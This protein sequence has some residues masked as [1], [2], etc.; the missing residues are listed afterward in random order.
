MMVILQSEEHD[1]N[2]AFCRNILTSLE[3]IEFLRLYQ[4]IVWG[5]NVRRTEAFQVSNI[6]EATTYPFIAIIALQTSPS[7]GSSLS[8]PKMSVI[9]RIEGPTTSAAVIRRFQNV[10]A[11]TE[12]NINRMR[13]EREQR[14][15]E[16][17]LRREQ[18]RAYAE[19]LRIDR[20]REKRI[21][22]ERQAAAMRERA[23][24]LEKKNRKL[25]IRYLCQKLRDDSM[26]SNEK[27]VRISF[28][29]ADGSRAIRKFKGSD[30]LETLY[31]FVE[32][33]PYMEIYENESCIDEVPEDYVH[34]YKFTVHSAYPRT[35]YQAD[36]EKKIIDEKSLWPSATLIVDP[37]DEDE[38]ENQEDDDE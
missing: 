8:S 9:D 24:L 3:L 37:E 29:M 30:T 17:A 14:E 21:M 35:V 13:A 6:L 7:S 22:R 5:G 33:H 1:D 11:R 28:R 32:A 12:I 18:E 2:D 10:I 26:D 23:R 31:Q 25:Y 34:K 15:Q 4:V 16:Q 36:P 20:E 27:T 19:S 38:E